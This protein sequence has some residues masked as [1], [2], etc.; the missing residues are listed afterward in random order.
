[1]RGDA[2]DSYRAR[3]EL[4]LESLGALDALPK[5]VR[6]DWN[7]LAEASGK[8]FSTWDRASVWRRRFGRDQRLLTTACRSSDGEL[9]AVLPL[10]IERRPILADR[11]IHRSPAPA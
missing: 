6:A 9:V 10:Y 5:D 4:R 1:M 2:I 7:R 8:I 3:R 11:A